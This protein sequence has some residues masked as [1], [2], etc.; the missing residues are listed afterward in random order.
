MSPTLN[1]FR[2]FQPF[3]STANWLHGQVRYLLDIAAALAL[4]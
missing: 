2:I 3:R 1:R 4:C